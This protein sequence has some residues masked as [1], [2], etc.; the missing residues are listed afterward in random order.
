MNKNINE[1]CK[2]IINEAIVPSIDIKF[3]RKIRIPM[4]FLILL[5]KTVNYL[6]FPIFKS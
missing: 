4:W 5:F 2:L 6:P 1:K 3:Y